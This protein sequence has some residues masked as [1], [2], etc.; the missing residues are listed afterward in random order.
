MG[1]PCGRFWAAVAQVMKINDLKSALVSFGL[2]RSEWAAKVWLTDVATGRRNV[3]PKP[4]QCLDSANREGIFGH[5]RLAL[6]DDVRHCYR[7]KP[8]G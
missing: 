3:G 7:E 8:C 5:A 1:L 4:I 2:V 6:N